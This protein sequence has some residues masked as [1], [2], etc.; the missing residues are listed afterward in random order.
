MKSN[1]TCSTAAEAANGKRRTPLFRTDKVKCLK[2][3][4][5]D[6]FKLRIER[7]KQFRHV[8]LRDLYH[9]QTVQERLYKETTEHN[10]V[11]F[12]TWDAPLLT[13]LAEKLLAGK[14]LTAKQ[15]QEL[16]KRLPKYWGQFTTTN[17]VELPAP[18][19]PTKKAS[20]TGK[21]EKAA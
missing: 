6:S 10:L 14:A 2:R 11:G 12:Q 8:V 15:E 3:T 5:K 19:T 9:H 1:L 21:K 7:G 13:K 4:A 18:T 20:K 17:L 16:I